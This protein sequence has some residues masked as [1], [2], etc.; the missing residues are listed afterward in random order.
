MP[1]AEYASLYQLKTPQPLVR[2]GL[3]SMVR[4]ARPVLLTL[5]FLVFPIALLATGLRWWRLM[6]PLGIEMSLKTAYALNMVGVFYN[7]FMLAARGGDFVKAFYAGKHARPGRKT[8]ACS[9]CSW[10]G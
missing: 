3:A 9:A 7:T 5:S 1:P 8:A 2:I 6:R 4:D 10:T